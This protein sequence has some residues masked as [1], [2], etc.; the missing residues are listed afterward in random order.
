M[1]RRGYWFAAF[2]AAGL[3]MA[4]P[5]SVYAMAPCTAV[6]IEEAT[7][8]KSEYVARLSAAQ[9]DLAVMRQNVEILK[10]Q[11]A[12]GLSM[13]QATNAVTNQENVVR[14]LT[15]QVNNAQ[16]FIDNATNKGD[17]ETKNKA[18]LG[19]LAELNT[20]QNA[21]MD[22][23]NKANI[24]SAAYTNVENLKKA[25]AGYQAM[26]ATSPSVQT[27]IDEVSAKLS[28][29]EADYAAKKAA[30]DAANATFSSDFNT[31]NWASYDANFMNYVANRYDHN[32]EFSE[33][34]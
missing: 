10:A 34:K 8:Q 18:N 30:L 27:Q 3:A 6:T 13:L 24:A 7:A 23:E 20:L 29:A 5:A 19:Y 22:A 4:T 28:E 2:A 11:G 1:N 17:V 21:K 26:L 15:D 33:N 9:A 14:W 25:L 31:L 16:A 12:D 32:D